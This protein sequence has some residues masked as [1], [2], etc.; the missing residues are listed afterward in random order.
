MKD[1]LKRLYSLYAPGRAIPEEAPEGAAMDLVPQ[2]PPLLD[3]AGLE[4]L[5]RQFASEPAYTLERVR[6]T[7]DSSMTADELRDLIVDLEVTFEDPGARVAYDLAFEAGLG[8]T[9]LPKEFTFPRMDR[10]NIP[11]DT[12]DCRFETKRDAIGWAL[13]AGPFFLRGKVY[14]PKAKFRWAENYPSLFNYRLRGDRKTRLALFSDAGTG[15]YHSRYIGQHIG[16]E[17]WDHVL[18]LGD[19]YYSGKADEFEERFTGKQSFGPLIA[20]NSFWTLNANHEMFSGATPYFAAIDARRKANPALNEQEGSYFCLRSDRFQ[21]VGIDTAYHDER[22]HAEP[23]LALWLQQVLREGKAKGLTNILLSGD[24]P[25]TVGDAKFTSLF[26]DVTNGL[27]PNTIDL[28]VFGNVH[29]AAFFD[30]EA[31]GGAS[32]LGACIGHGGY[33]YSC[34]NE[35]QRWSAVPVRWLETEARFPTWTGVR[36]DRGNNGYMTLELDNETGSVLLEFI[37]WTADVRYRATLARQ[38]A[39][40]PLTIVNQERCARSAHGKP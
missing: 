15:L 27:P 13:N 8:K 3:R 37:D 26:L 14:Q 21:V 10:S 4:Q 35:N 33:P 11:I 16:A 29:Y 39:G 7:F 12:T 30:R 32:F 25:Y 31:E 17:K 38:L 40:G 1:D 5:K 24:E 20:A 6:A 18:Y 28:W 9:V 23:K 2:E 36:Q 22:R 19:V 34:M